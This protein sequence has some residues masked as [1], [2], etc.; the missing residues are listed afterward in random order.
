M[1]QT[2]KKTQTLKT[3]NK[4]NVWDMQENDIQRMWEAA[5][6]DADLRDNMQHYRNIIQSAFNFEEVV[7]DKPQVI[8]K[9]EERGYKV[10]QIKAGDSEKGKWAIKKKAILRTTDLTYDNIHHISPSK[11]IEVLERNFGGGWESLPQSVKDIIESGFDIST[12]TLPADRLKKKGG[13]YD[14]KVKEGF[15]VLEIPQGTWIEAIFIKQKPQIE[16]PQAKAEPDEK[17]ISNFG[18]EEEG[19]EDLPEIEDSYEE[20]EDDD[21]FDEDK[22]TEESYRTTF[23]TDPEDLDLANA[24]VTDDDEY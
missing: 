16:I 4:S 23:D 21:E 18:D 1:K 20:D 8:A 19:D 15:D 12:T 5:E 17:H 14:M 13:M 24:D 22:L 3:L 9:Y 7:V 2:T 6:R 11:L 10:I